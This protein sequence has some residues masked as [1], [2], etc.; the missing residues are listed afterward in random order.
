MLAKACLETGLNNFGDDIFIEALEK[1]V[2]SSNNDT[3]LSPMG[4]AAVEGEIHRILVNRLRFAEDLKKHPEILAED[5]ADPIIILGMPRTG[6]T[7]L[8]RMMSSDPDVQR[9]DY[10]RLLNPAP[11][12]GEIN[13]EE[14][15]RIEAARQ[16]VIMTNQL[17]PDW[18]ASHPTEA[19]DVDEEVYLQVFSFKSIITCT[20][21]QVPSYQEWLS[22]Q[23]MR[24]TYDY[25]RMLLQYLQWQDGGKRGRPWIMKSPVH[26]GTTDILMEMFPKATLV[27]THRDIYTA[28]ASICRLM[29][30]IWGL[31]TDHV[32]K[33]AIGQ[34]VRD[35]FLS[36]LKKH[37]RLR[38]EMGT[39]LDILDVQYA[40][41]KSDPLKVIG[42]IYQRAGRE[43]TAERQGEMLEWDSKHRQHAEGKLNY[44]LQD[45]GLNTQVIDA[46]CKEY[47]DK[48]CLLDT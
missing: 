46:D 27:F 24:Y 33:N 15:P 1:L 23:S 35:V 22:T 42:E 20:G 12:P 30:S 2:D 48:F 25:M 6:T 17:M 44:R 3:A 32:D 21:R 18:K 11:F 39:K 29:E 13:A 34:T 10:W 38:D 16:A 9:L 14:D 41:I 7:K 43:L 28:V 40:E 26:M 37:M 5:V 4:V 45:Y 19:D 8:Q 36:E 31:Y 47:M